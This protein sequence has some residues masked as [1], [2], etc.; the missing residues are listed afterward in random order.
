MF[1][2][3]PKRAELKIKQPRGLL[4]YGP[5]GNGKT[6]IARSL[7]RKMNCN[8]I[9]V[10]ASDFQSNVRIDPDLDSDPKKERDDAD[11][12]P[13]VAARFAV[14]RPPGEPGDKVDPYAQ[15]DIQDDPYAQADAQDKGAGDGD[16]PDGAPGDRDSTDQG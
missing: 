14:P 12:K 6:M 8:F 4:L 7:A 10:A 1:L 3:A 11:S 5:Q 13:A 2:D 15:A 9:A 16:E